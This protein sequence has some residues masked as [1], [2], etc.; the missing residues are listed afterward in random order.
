MHCK[1]LQEQLQ[2]PID[3]ALITIDTTTGAVVALVGGADFRTSKFNR[4]LAAKRQIGSIIKPLIYAL[5]VEDGMTFADSIDDEP[6]ELTV[7]G[8]SWKPRNY[9]RQFH[10]SITL[11]YALSHSSNIAAVKLLM[12]CG[13]QRVCKLARACGIHSSLHTFPSLALGC[14]DATLYDIAGMIRI[15]AHDGLYSEPYAIAWVKNQWGEKIFH[16]APESCRVLD[17]RVVGQVNRVLQLGIARACRASKEQIS[18][19]AIG[20]TGTTNDSRTCWYAGATPS[21]TTA[22]YIGCDDNRSMGDNV[23]PVRTALPIWLSLNAALSHDQKTFTRDPSL[24]E[25]TIDE[26]TGR[27]VLAHHP[28]AITIVI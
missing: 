20:K 11:A 9:D 14:I 7:E 17:S 19:Q 3:G 5:A 12:S 24:R 4:A 23:Y 16:A 2:Q 8:K 13:P 27:T 18:A 1:K 28:R 25:I 22:I 21:Y 6:L 26:K 15:F 10:G